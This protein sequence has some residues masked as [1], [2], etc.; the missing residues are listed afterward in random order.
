MQKMVSLGH[1]QEPQ[2]IN[3]KPRLATNTWE[4]FFEGIYIYSTA[5]ELWSAFLET[6]TQDKHHPPLGS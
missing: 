6:T 3:G 4:C 1:N 2:E 5:L